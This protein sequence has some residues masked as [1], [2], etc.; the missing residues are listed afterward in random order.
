MSGPATERSKRTVK[1]RWPWVLGIGAL[2]LAIAGFG[3]DR[4]LKSKRHPGL[5]TFL[6]QLVRNYPIGFAHEPETI[7]ISID[8]ADLEQLER[9]VEEARARGVIL[10]EGNSY[11]PARIDGGAGAFEAKVR[12]KGKLTDHV[13]DRKWSLRVIAKKDGG[14]KGMRRFSLQHPGTRNYLCDWFYHRLMQ[15]EGVAALRYGFVRVRFNGDDLGI[16]A[17]EE[18]FGPELLQNNGRADGPIFRFDPALFWEHRLNEMN[19][20][21]FDEPFAAYQAASLDAFGSSDL[22]KDKR[23]REQFEEAVARFEAFR[24]GKLTASQVFDADRI[25]RHHAILDLVGGHHSMDWSDVKFYFDPL[26]KR[27]EPVSYESF[28]SN[29]IR[30]LAGS[31][32]YT[33][34]LSQSMDLHAQ[35]FNDEELFRAYVMHLERVSRKAWLDSAFAALAPALDSASATVYREFPYKELDRA[36]YYKNQKVIRKLLD[37][38]KAFHAYLRD[39]GAD[40][41]RI[42]VVP[43]EALPMEVHALVLNDGTRVEPIGKAIVPIRKAGRMGEPMELRFVV[44]MKLERG[45]LKLECSVLGASVRRTVDVFPFAL[46]DG[47]E[48]ALL[49]AADPR[50]LPFLDVDDEARIITIKPGVWDVTQNVELPAG[51]TVRATAP[52]SLRIAKDV[53]FLSRSPL[54][55]KGLNEA[56]ITIVNYGELVLLECRKESVLERVQVEGTGRVIVQESAVRMKRC[57]FQSSGEGDQITM[58]RSTATLKDVVIAGGTDALNLIASDVSADQC[59]VR[60]PKDDGVVVRGGKLVWKS[61]S[62]EGGKGAGLKLGVQGDAVL[63]GAAIRSGGHGVQVRDGASLK[64]DRCT[65]E[66][67]ELGIAVEDIERISGPS[68]VSINATSITGGAGELSSG[69][70]NTVLRDGKAVESANSEAPKKKS[71]KKDKSE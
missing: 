16:Y 45:G 33:G 18:H 50:A 10:P 58:V 11:V 4:M 57:A 63:E 44:P 20:V 37:P 41:V 2:V 71:K 40:T 36:V 39:N 24:R 31:N 69:K 34:Q 51:Y 9:V 49:S 62:I 38:P 66:A 26:L 70:G 12:I 29:A 59:E 65:I 28:S 52:L 32:K 64:L 25:A 7:A 55:W 35:W 60:G 67:K 23:F 46:R 21:R 42:T 48:L 30:T 8:E 22:E 47:E 5:S 3:A 56:A 1:R 17:Y 27:I 14:Y 13:K 6:K 53:R 43:I 15:A 54:D 19:K 61:G 68:R